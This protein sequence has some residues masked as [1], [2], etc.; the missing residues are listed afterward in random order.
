VNVFRASR[1][2]RLALVATAATAS[3]LA[4]ACIRR[5]Q[6][7]RTTRTTAPVTAP[8]T[9]PATT[10]TTAPAT[11][12]T[13]GH[14]H[15]HDEPGDDKGWSLLGN[16]HQHP[17]EDEP[18]DAATQ[19][20][21]DRQIAVTQQLVAKYPTVAEAVAAGYR[22]AGPFSP[23]LGAHYMEPFNP[24]SLTGG[25]A[26]GT[27]AI[28]DTQLLHPML[29]FN[30]VTPDAPLIGFM[31]MTMGAQ[32]I[33]E[34][35]AGPN[36]IWHYHNNVCIAFG[37]GGIETPL[38]ADREITPEQ[39]SAAGGRLIAATGYMAHLWSVPGWE[40]PKGL[41]AEL[42]PKVTCKDGTYW[43]IPFDQLG[44]NTTTCRDEAVAGT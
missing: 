4:S 33:P 25:T 23:G 38:G 7:P 31:Y 10:P 3:L 39:C 18:L 19:Q 17:H 11:T 22:R 40:N 1:R 2:S 9:A 37:A 26:S 14:G 43:Q 36:D 8:T 21:L 5:P 6:P 44:H 34:G 41:F 13:T 32:A 28:T 16:G 20:E 42:N 30:G 35:F 29:V 27:G 15:G 12:T 24:A